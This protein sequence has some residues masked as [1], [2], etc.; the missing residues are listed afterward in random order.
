[1]AQ[2]KTLSD[3]TPPR[4]RKPAPFINQ[5]RSEDRVPNAAIDLPGTYQDAASA[6]K[7]Q[8]TL[9][10]GTYRVVQVKTPWRTLKAVRQPVLLVVDDGA[11]EPAEEA[12][13]E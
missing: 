12:T 5:K 13:P 7:A 2:D 11:P 3:A 1:M 8:F 6:A 10:A 9:G 4:R